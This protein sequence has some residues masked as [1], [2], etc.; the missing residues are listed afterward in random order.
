MQA[1]HTR[2]IRPTNSRGARI[3]AYSEAFPRGVLAEI[4]RDG[5]TLPEV[6]P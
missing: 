6:K 2:Y 1:I 5:G 3:K 4:K